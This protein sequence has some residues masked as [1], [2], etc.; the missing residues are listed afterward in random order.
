MTAAAIAGLFLAGVAGGIV[1]VLVSLVSLVTYP[2]LLAVGLPPVAANVTN[3]VSLT[4]TGLGAAIGSRRELEGQRPMLLRLA[5]VAALGGL[6]GAALLLVLPGRAFELVAPVLI[7]GASVV[8]MLQ[9]RLKERAVFR[10]RGLEAGTVAAF[11]LTAVY[12]GYFGAAGGVLGLV[13]LGMIMIRPLTHMIAAKN[14]LAGVS[15]G[16]A[17]IAFALF[18]PVAWGYVVPLAAGL[19][20]GG[21]I[22]PG[23]ARRLPAALLRLLIG[24]C[25]LS[26]A[27]VLAWHTYL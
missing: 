27:A 1:S 21:L 6:T 10:P 16:V 26:V 23:I 20:V 2:A 11:Y 8:V 12:T 9:P 14:V 24:V 15:N 18:G 5:V 13:A 7:A 25:G 4:F 3:T 17:A 22:G 19:F